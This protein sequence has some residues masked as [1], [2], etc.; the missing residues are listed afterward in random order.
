MPPTPTIEKI[1]ENHD[2]FPVQGNKPKFD[3]VDKTEENLML[4]LCLEKK[5]SF[6]REKEENLKGVREK[7]KKMEEKLKQKENTQQTPPP[8]RKISLKKLSLEKKTTPGVKKGAGVT[9]IEKEKLNLKGV[10][11]KLQ[12]GKDLRGIIGNCGQPSDILP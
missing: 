9:K 5:K 11:E 7:I 12:F 1:E 6:G 3:F 8:K 2:I 4:S 10:K